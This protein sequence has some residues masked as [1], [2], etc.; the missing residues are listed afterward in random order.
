MSSC[1]RLDV[2]SCAESPRT[3]ETLAYDTFHAA[4]NGLSA[5]SLTNI[6]PEASRLTVSEQTALMILDANITYGEGD[7]AKNKYLLA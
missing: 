2:T 5:A 1:F 6:H 7:N 3:K 4:E